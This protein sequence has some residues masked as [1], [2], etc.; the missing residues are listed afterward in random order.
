[1]GNPVAAHIPSMMSRYE[2]SRERRENCFR[3]LVEC[4][5]FPCA[6][7][8]GFSPAH[9]PCEIAY[10]GHRIGDLT[11]LVGDGRDRE[12]GHESALYSY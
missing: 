6:L 7:E 4:E 11:G 2:S 9:T 10:N 5:Q 8:D 12:S 1:M 3:E